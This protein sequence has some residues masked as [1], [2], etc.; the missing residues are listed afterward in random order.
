[1][2]AGSLRELI[3]FYKRIAVSDG[4]G[5]E[6]SDF[7]STAEFT[8]AA[9]IAP[10]LGGETILAGRLQGSDTVNITVRYSSASA[11]V[12]PDWCI[13]DERSGVRYNIRS[14]INPDQQRRYLEILAQKGVAV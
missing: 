11:A 14:I 9:E 2:V 12:T 7:A 13:K 8:C 4:A 6:E 1:M 10:K 5:N 3:G